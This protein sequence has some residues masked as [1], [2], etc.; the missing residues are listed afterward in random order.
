MLSPG[1]TGMPLSSLFCSGLS[2]PGPRAAENQA[3]GGG[4]LCRGG[5]ASEGVLPLHALA[6]RTL[7]R[8]EYLTGRDPGDVY[9]RA[10]LK[11]ATCIATS[12]GNSTVSA[13]TV[14][15]P[16]AI[17]HDIGIH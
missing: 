10:C 8:N 2:R 5:H 15:F 3:C 13:H 11:L 17:V 1:G 7:P 4:C 16:R 9:F 14:P 6:R 12:R